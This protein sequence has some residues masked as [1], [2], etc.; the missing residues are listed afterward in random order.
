MLI[1]LVFLTA[2]FL[3]F[4]SFSGFFQNLFFSFLLLYFLA[5]SVLSNVRQLY[6]KYF[7]QDFTRQISRT[8]QVLVMHLL[9]IV[10]FNGIL[11]TY[12]SRAIILYTY[13]FLLVA[14]PLW[15]IFYN[16]II[17]GYFLLGYGVKQAIF[18][19]G[20]NIN[21][22][23]DEFESSRISSIKVIG[24]FGE[25]SD[26]QYSRLGE[27][28]DWYEFL[29]SNAEEIDE[30][31]C[32][33][34]SLSGKDLNKLIS[35]ADNNLIRIIFIPEAKGLNFSKLKFDFIGQQPVMVLRPLPLDEPVNRLVKRVFDIIFSTLVIGL[36]LIWLFPIVAILIKLTSRGPILFKQ[37]RSGL[38][39]DLFWCYKFRTMRV[40][41][42]SETKQAEKNDSR[43]TR[44]GDFLRRTSL[45]EMPQ[46]IN[47]FIGNMSVVGP[48]PH[49][50]SHTELYSKI[51]N[52]FMLRHF[53]KPGITGLSQVKGLRGETTEPSAM[54]N[55]VRIDIFYIE[56][57]SFLL[58]IK[59]VMLTVYNMVRGDKN[60]F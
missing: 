18:I 15:R 41:V 36:V 13:G 38:N 14:L 30:V 57:W 35:F 58:D 39:N 37:K 24:Y 50:I 40:N 42:E 47:V 56:Y 8:L 54:R 34:A 21:P 7:E 1:T 22:L 53:V 17:R 23:I 33:I 6:G 51:I 4:E 31:Y 19:G 45:D 2:Y 29:E 52:K 12:F 27:A 49:M 26:N 44:I 10:A 46:F 28:N 55:R 60:A 32:S 11:K 20:D 9:V 25:A 59:I 16:R 3:R 48:R 43:I 5:W